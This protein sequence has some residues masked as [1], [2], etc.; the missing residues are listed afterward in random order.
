MAN[1]VLTPKRVEATA[2]D[3]EPGWAMGGAAAAAT[4]TGNAAGVA[5]ARTGKVMTAEGAF[6][7]AFLLWLIVVAAAA[8][9]WGKT[10]V[11]QV[12][13]I[14]IPGWTWPALFIGLGLAMLTIFKPKFAPITAP[15]YAAA[16]GLFLGVISKIYDAQW[17]GIVLQAVLATVGVF[18]VCLAL[19]VTGVVKVTKKF[20]FVVIAATAGIMVMYLAGFLLNMFGVDI[21]FWNE[22]SALG[23]LFSVGICIVAALNLFLDFEMIRRLGLAKAPKAMEWYGAFGLTVTMVWLYLEILRLL[24]KLRN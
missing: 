13:E 10:A 22:P 5:P 6:G 11:P 23:I 4:M 7:K 16:E 1:P 2:E 18:L 20:V 3:L 17:N 19:Y 21:T 14:K 8:F 24:S 12:G 15:L 9:S